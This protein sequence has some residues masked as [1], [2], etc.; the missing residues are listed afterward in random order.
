[1]YR[2]VFALSLLP[3]SF[4]AGQD[5]SKRT[6]EIAA[7]LPEKPFCIGRPVT[8]RHAWEAL[9]EN[10]FVQLAEKIAATPIPDLT[11][12][13]YKEYF[14]NGN[15]RN[16]QNAQ[17][18]KYGRL[19]LLTLAECLENKG[20]FLKPLEEVIRSVCA[21]RSWLLPAHD[22]NNASVYDGKE[23]FI[24]L[25][26]SYI[27]AELGLADSFLGT[28][29]QPEIRK[30]IREN[31]RRRTFLPYEQSV[32]SGING[33]NKWIT[34]ANN[35][36]SVCHAGVVCAALTLID[37]PQQRAWYIAAAEQFMVPFFRGFTP[38]G[39]C[40]EGIGYWNY[41]FGHFV[42]LAEMVYQATGGNVDFFAIPEVAACALFAPKM[43][44]AAHQFAAF[45]DCRPDARPDAELLKF[46][47]RRMQWGDNGL[48]CFQN[49]LDGHLK[50]T[51]VFCFPNSASEKPLAAGKTPPLS[52]FRSEFTDAGILICRHPS[53]GER[54][55][56]F[57]CKAGHNAELHN[58]NDIGS[59]T[60]MYAGT[61]PV[62][63]P[64]GEVYTRRTFSDKRYDSNL[65][66][67]FGHPVPVI[68]GQR[69]KTGKQFSGK[70]V[71]KTFTDEK[72]VCT[73]DYAA[74]YGLQEIRK[75]ERTFTF[76]RPAD[77][78]NSL[79]VEDNIL[80]E[81]AGTFET[82]LLTYEAW[83]R[84]ENGDGSLHGGVVLIGRAGK[85]TAVSFSAE[86]DGRAVLPVVTDSEI[87][88][89]AM[90]GRKPVRLAFAVK[91]PAK[92]IR[93]T[94]V[95][96]LPETATSSAVRNPAAAH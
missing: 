17:Q 22:R 38:D 33:Q 27:S 47:N 79:T 10:N 71:T 31:V 6:A 11:E 21:D 25:S 83:Q 34:A 32:R 59:F 46:L 58:H 67:S 51:A 56:H 82:A 93:M 96:T 13:L 3:F 37:E 9:P 81:P 41:G 53:G 50:R 64:G 8:D 26:S 78:P 12:E 57:V 88:E 18:Q 76:M 89:D 15:R 4:L 60:V 87:D 91:E 61:L 19:S 45:A 29:L 77:A 1:M 74:A 95:F 2:I 55:L 43:E 92:K 90:A 80:L 42:Y 30:M 69:Q 65:L 5:F 72:D 75:L 40:S 68:N 62:L 14:R 39:Y 85:Q 84:Q 23:E 52:D 35:W 20:R 66:N 70:I 48:D 16:Y 36:N 44:V 63:D 24:D 94:M 49:K 73:I 28:Q 86:A 54:A 7:F